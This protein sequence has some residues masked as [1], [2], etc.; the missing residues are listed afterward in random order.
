MKYF[1]YVA[2]LLCVLFPVMV[3]AG[4]L[5]S[6]AAPTDAGSAM[7]TLEQIYDCLNGGDCDAAPRSGVFT[8]PSTGPS[9]GTSYS[10][11]AIM[12][13]AKEAMSGGGGS[14]AA[15]AKTGI[16]TCSDT[17]GTTI[18]CA[19]TGQDGDLQKRR[20]IARPAFC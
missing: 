17:A 14:S 5:D 12:A 15:V 7:N 3:F 8:E 20:G 1:K 6:P 19:G 4:D 18:P 10:L 9:S 2:I 13:K 11:N 16:T